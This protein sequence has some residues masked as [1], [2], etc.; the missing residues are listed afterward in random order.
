[1][2]RKDFEKLARRFDRAVKAHD[3]TYRAYIAS[4]TMTSKAA[5]RVYA[6]AKPDVCYLAQ[7]AE[8]KARMAW[9]EAERTYLAVK[10]DLNEAQDEFYRSKGA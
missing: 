9:Q 5:A 7:T 6:G 2:T 4:V 1:M 8:S 3:K 10:A